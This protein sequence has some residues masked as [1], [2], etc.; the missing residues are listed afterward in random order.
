M[1]LTPEEEADRDAF[2]DKHKNAL[3]ETEPSVWADD[4]LPADEILAPD[5]KPQSRMTL[6]LRWIAVLPAAV[7]AYFVIQLVIILMDATMA[8]RHA[9]WFLQL[10][11]SGA[12]SYAFV[13]AGA[14]TAPKHQFIV[15]IILATIFV[16]SMIGLLTLRIF[17]ETSDPLWWLALAGV[18]SI[19]AAIAAVKQLSEGKWQLK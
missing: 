6:A 12:S 10:I 4:D 2:I 9:E 7:A 15:S 8:E 13:F 1:P 18:I 17:V 19:I 11:N 3:E 5:S 16:V 14:Y